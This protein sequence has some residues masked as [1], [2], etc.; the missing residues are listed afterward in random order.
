MSNYF[1]ASNWK[2]GKAASHNRADSTFQYS[3]QIVVQP[4]QLSFLLRT[5][6]NL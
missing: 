1:P 3:E 2:D 6:I 4:T 5:G